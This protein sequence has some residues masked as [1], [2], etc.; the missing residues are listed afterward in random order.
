MQGDDEMSKPSLRWRVASRFTMSAI[1]L[2]CKSFLVL[3]SST[4]IHG[5]EAFKTLLDERR[6]VAN[7]K[8]G[9]LTGEQTTSFGP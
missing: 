7:R 3:A 2:L 8:R 4:K 6:D 1:G 5:L 9:L